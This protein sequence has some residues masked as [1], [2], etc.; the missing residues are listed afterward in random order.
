MPDQMVN[1]IFE[2][3]PPHL[4][5]LNFLVGR[6][7]NLLL[8][9]INL[10]VETV[11]FIEHFS[12]MVIGALKAPDDVT[13]FGKFTKDGMMKVHDDVVT[14]LGNSEVNVGW[15]TVLRGDDC[16]A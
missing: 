14:L 2:P 1:V 15:S 12:K 5:L 8:D 9:A 6:K 11:I 16:S 13:V 4:E 3:R 7:V 10:V